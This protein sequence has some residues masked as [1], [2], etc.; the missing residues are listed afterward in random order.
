MKRLAITIC[1]LF[2]AGTALKAVAADPPDVPVKYAQAIERQVERAEQGVAEGPFQADFDDLARATEAPEWFRDAKFGIYFHWGVYS[3][4]AHGSEW[5][6]RNMHKGSTYKHHKKTYGEP[7]AYPY[8]KFVPQFRAEKFDADAWAELFQKAGARYAGPVAEHH[9]GY[10]MWDSAVTPWN[11]ADTGPKRDIAGELAEA[12]RRHGM[13]FVATFHHA[14]NPGHY[15]GVRK[16]FPSLLDDPIDAFLYGY[17]PRKRF[18]QLWLAKLVEVIDQYQPDLI[19]FDSWLHEIP[20]KRRAQFAA[21]Y[22]NRAADWGKQVVITRK[23]NDLPT[24]FSLEDFEKGR[25]NKLTEHWWLTDDTISTGSWCY[26]DNLGIKPTRRV[27]HDFIDIV[28]KRGCLLLNISPKA[29]GTIPKNQRDVLLA[30]GRWLA[31][32]GQA[33]YNT[34]PWNVFGEGPAKMKRGG[35]FVGKVAYGPNDIRFTQSKDGR[36]LYAI[37]LGWPADALVLDRV[38]IDGAAGGTVTL[39]GHDQ[40]LEYHVRDGRLAI[41]M[42]NLSEQHRPCRHAYALK[43]SGFQLSH[44]KTAP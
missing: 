30:M 37:A 42:P 4:P 44:R 3:V 23:Q 15:S 16:H 33:V 22:Y 9:D 19:W 27:L 2:A 40:P 28:S 34:R 29:D 20:E 17:M 43:L 7:D 38:Q 5:Y 32:N 39:L 35:G 24:T 1:V 8:T 11:A 21:Y 18:E 13:K 10:A 41:D 12:I 25:A 14:R 26:T 36:I 31:V 6:P